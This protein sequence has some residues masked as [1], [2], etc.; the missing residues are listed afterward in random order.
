MPHTFRT[1]SCFPAMSKFRNPSV[2][3]SSAVNSMA[4]QRR[5]ARGSTL[6]TALV[7]HMEGTVIIR[8]WRVT[9]ARCTSSCSLP[10]NNSGVRAGSGALIAT[11]IPR[12][13]SYR[14]RNTLVARHN[15]WV[16]WVGAMR[17]EGKRT[18]A[19]GSARFVPTPMLASAPRS[20]HILCY[21]FLSFLIWSIININMFSSST[22]VAT[23][24]AL[25]S[26]TYGGDKV[27]RWKS[28]NSAR[29]CSAVV[30]P[31]SQPRTRSNTFNTSCDVF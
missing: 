1:S 23:V 13:I 9:P 30:P 18:R 6:P 16:Q 7:R 12:K 29:C 19:F 20:R 28:A 8:C 2:S 5:S 24:L 17:C 11:P 27:R 22:F 4:L 3:T 25:V 15:G 26:G 31:F 14:H 21:P 10:A